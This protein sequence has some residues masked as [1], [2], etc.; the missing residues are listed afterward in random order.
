[1]R[2]TPW[3]AFCTLLACFR[4]LVLAS[5]DRATVVVILGNRPEAIKLAP[6]ISS[7]RSSFSSDVEVRIVSSGQ[8]QE[9][10]WPALDLFRLVPDINLE[11]MQFR[12][13]GSAVFVSRAMESISRVLQN[14]IPVPRAV[15]VQGDTDTALAGAMAAFYEHIPVV[16]VEAGL[17]T[18]DISFPH[19]EEFNRRA[20]STIAA[21]SLA[22][23]NYSKENLMKSGVA[24]DSIKVTG[25]TAIDS[26]INIFTTIEDVPEES[27]FSQLILN[28]IVN[29]RGEL[30]RFVIVSSQR[31]DID[32]SLQNIMHA[33]RALARIY[34]DV[35]FVYIRHS[36]QQ[37]H[38]PVSELLENIENVI[39]LDYV[40]YSW[41]LRLIGHASLVLTD[42]SDLQEEAAFMGVR[43]IVLR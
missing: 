20:I 9:L 13:N 8:Q 2:K 3:A 40:E 15:I 37:T 42:S 43:C 24:M 35:A 19:P 30:K 21:L 12:S 32:Y 23:T 28:R 16:H 10:L 33:V 31:R 25:S 39:I 41:L 29:E 5:A 18:W 17:C 22:P 6:V 27:E 14:M 4:A 11:L 26:V 38:M 7:L 34:P 1:M 36:S